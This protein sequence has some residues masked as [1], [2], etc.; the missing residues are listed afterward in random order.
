LI[1]LGLKDVNNCSF[2]MS[3]VDNIKKLL[4]ISD[5]VAYGKPS[6]T[7][8]ENVIRKRGFLRTSDGKR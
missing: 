8:V 7:T 5:Y 4:L 2:V 3:T 6:K 1:E